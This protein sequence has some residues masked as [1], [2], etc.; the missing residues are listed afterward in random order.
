MQNVSEKIRRDFIFTNDLPLQLQEVR[1]NIEN[2]NAVFIHLRGGD[3]IDDA[4]NR[5]LYG[6][7]CTP[8]YYNKAVSMMKS[9]L[10][11][12]VFYVFTNDRKYAQSILGKNEVNYISDHIGT[13]YED[14]I[15][16]MLMS[17]L[18]LYYC[19]GVLRNSRLRR[20]I[21]LTDSHF[22]QQYRN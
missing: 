21:Y 3:Y 9:R 18:L 2:C 17:K 7:I 8:N 14:W 13:A 20:K 5:K 10:D 22:A 15:D 16:M 4:A 6:N 1:K 12:P 19:Y 11:E